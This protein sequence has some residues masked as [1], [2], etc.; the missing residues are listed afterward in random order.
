MKGRFLTL[1]NAITEHNHRQL[2]VISGNQQWCL[3]Q[4][5]PLLSSFEPDQGLWLGDRAP[6]SI[7]SSKQGKATQWL[8]R[9]RQFVVFNA[10]SGFDVDA[11]GAISGVIRGGGI[12]F[13]LTPTL[14]QWSLFDDPEHRRIAVYPETDA[15][16]TGRYI[17][18]L[19]RLFVSSED[20]CLLE[21]GKK[22]R[23][24]TLHAPEVHALEVHAPEELSALL[25]ND[26]CRTEEQAQ[27][28]SAVIR[29]ATGHR[30]RPMVLTA[31][32]GRGKSA[33]LGI[34]AAQLLQ[35]GATHIV[36]TGPSLASTEQVFQHCADLLEN[37]SESRGVLEWQDKTLRFMAPDDITTDFGG[38]KIDCDL[39]LVDEAAAL[40]VP[41]LESLLRQ[42]SRIVFSSTIHGYEG[43][44]RGFAIRF[45]KT[46]DQM[47]PKWRGLHMRQ[48]I[49]W[50]DGDPLEQMVFNSLLLDARPAADADIAQA[51]P[52]Q[53]EWIHFDRDQLAS[54]ET[55]LR[56]VFGLLVL[57]HYRTRP[58]DLRHFLDGPNIEVFGLLYQ[59]QLVGI[60]LAAQEGGIEP[61]LQDAIWLGQRR[62]RGHLI[63][64]SLS[65]HAGIPQAIR[66]NGLRI[67]RIAV[68]PGVQ[69]KRLGAD[70]LDHLNRSAADAGYDYLGTSFGATSDLLGFWQ[71]SDFQPVRVG[72]QREA[73]SGCYSVMMLKSLS[74]QGAE[75]VAEARIR[76]QE[77]L[78][79]QLPESLQ[80]MEPELATQLLQSV[81][82]GT[83]CAVR[84]RD[85]LDISSF[86]RG[87]RLYESCLPAIQRLL[88]AGLAG[89]DVDSKALQ[90]LVMKVLQ[91]Q[92]WSKLARYEALTGKKQCHA[93]LR[94]HVQLLE[95]TLNRHSF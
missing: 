36:V 12:L 6:D 2:F 41:L 77:S 51:I 58:F 72:L 80:S 63:P 42:Q 23:W 45:R 40:P 39:M 67:L 81:L 59:R 91:L 1:L 22:E 38:H 69:R 71:S 65:N 7:V 16:V 48:A 29:V 26:N 79:A 57:A 83:D 90:S 19:A 34:A 87:Q 73:A 85:W 60:V 32:R 13:L 68:H 25:E 14:Q 43:T 61:E 5:S 70:M 94:Q 50:A 3:S 56:Q 24:P 54:D 75:L 76:F 89:T 8:G 9:E 55:M 28:V 21:Q 35:Q 49:R 20:I 30:R 64:Q 62:V 78:L 11:F 52:N 46:L 82:Q 15:H 10:W 84:N 74:E 86:T 37:A 93:R 66:H 88:L 92:P 47:T 18:R 31:D 95:Q 4:L 44:G 17:E 33:A 53:C 27:A